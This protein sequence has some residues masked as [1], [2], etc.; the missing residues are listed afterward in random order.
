MKNQLFAALLGLIMFSST[1]CLYFDDGNIFNCV[2]GDGPVETFEL[3]IEPFTGIE[4]SGSME[5]YITQ[6]P[7][8]SVFIEGQENIVDLI[9]NDVNSGVWDIDFEGCVHSHDEVKV[10]ITVPEM[11]YVKL[12]GSGKI[13]SETFLNTEDFVLRLSGSGEIDLALEVE[14]IDGKISGSGEVKLEGIAESN[15]FSIT[16]S[17]DIEAFGLETQKTEIKISGS[18]NAEIL[19]NEILDVKITGSGDVFY[20]GYPVISVDITGSGDLVDAN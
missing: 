8:Q 7:N 2:N 1:S 15:D 17:G 6:G 18:G 14:D 4:M 19:A 16:G 5:V 13:V 11:N 3:D 20:R 10:Y 12:S 9:D